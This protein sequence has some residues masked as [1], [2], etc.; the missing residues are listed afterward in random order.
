MIRRDRDN[1]RIHVIRSNVDEEVWT[2]LSYGTRVSF[3]IA[4]NLEGPSGFEVKRAK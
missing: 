1:E 3:R 4:F 2:E